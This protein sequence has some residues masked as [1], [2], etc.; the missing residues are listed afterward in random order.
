M[1]WLISRYTHV[2][3][4]AASV[5][6]LAVVIAWLLVDRLAGP[7]P[8][9]R[10][11]ATPPPSVV[12]IPAVPDPDD[13]ATSA[14]R[15]PGR[16]ET[17]AGGVP[18]VS[19]PPAP[20][21][22][23]YALESGPFPPGEAADRLEAEL[24]RLGHA[25]VRFRKEDTARLFVVTATGFASADEARQAAR[26]IGRGTVVEEAGVPEVVLGRHSSLA[27]AV[28]AA[29]PIR[30]R[31]FEV[32]VSEALAPSGQYHI[33]Y[34]QFARRADAQ[35]YREALARRGIASRVVKVR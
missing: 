26:E 33:R 29:R 21:P 13:G 11:L 32:R 16:P 6:V 35:A 12:T 8:R 15:A 19:R 34:G 20:P 4:A 5:V 31:G 28:A 1:R 22:E 25:T 9:W 7:W 30:A 10:G 27:A 14:E 24:N 2:P 3:L 18:V 17:P 23:R